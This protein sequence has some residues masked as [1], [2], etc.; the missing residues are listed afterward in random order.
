MIMATVGRDAGR[1]MTMAHYVGVDVG[2]RSSSL[3]II[4]EMGTVCL[5]R[6]V[7]SE[8]EEIAVSI[9]CFADQVE[10]VALETG[11]LAAWLAMGLRAEG[12][13]SW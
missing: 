4:D 7:A 3:C 11:N 2:L 8:V 10:G 9:R 12:S 13:A 6:T 1:E 5:S